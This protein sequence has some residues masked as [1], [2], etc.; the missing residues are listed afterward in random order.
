V[1]RRRNRV[2]LRRSAPDRPWRVDIS[3][4][5]RP[6]GYPPTF[7]TVQTFVIPAEQ[8]IGPEGFGTPCN[9]EDLIFVEEDKDA[10]PPFVQHSRS[11]TKRHPGPFR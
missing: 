6:Y 1:L 7:N 2:Q 3:V 9:E 8:V 5:R 11:R 4:A 10:L